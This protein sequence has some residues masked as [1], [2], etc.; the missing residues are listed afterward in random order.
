LQR[1]KGVALAAGLL[2]VSDRRVSRPH[3]RRESIE[4]FF[5][6]R[7]QLLRVHPKRIGRARHFVFALLRLVLGFDHRAVYRVGID[8]SELVHDPNI[9]QSRG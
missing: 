6:N 2:G 8:P 1:Q 3:F 9:T 7:V 5:A 4:D